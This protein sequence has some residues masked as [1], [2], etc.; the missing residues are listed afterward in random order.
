M[1]V[2]YSETVRV[3]TESDAAPRTCVLSR[4]VN[5]LLGFDARRVMP[6]FV[7]N[8]S[9]G[10][11]HCG[12][13][14]IHAANLPKTE[15]QTSLHMKW[16][17]ADSAKKHEAHTRVLLVWASCWTCAATALKSDGDT[18]SPKWKPPS[19]EPV[20]EFPQLPKLQR[21][22]ELGLSRCPRATSHQESGATTCL[23]QHPVMGQRRTQ[24]CVSSNSLYH[25]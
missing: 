14:R 5:C 22:N 10:L 9:R 1:L 8:S 19:A 15:K 24:T 12:A 6:R 4:N 13:Q 2:N 7:S 17:I 3:H 18:S 25:S 16:S 20:W 23:R 21:K 11:H